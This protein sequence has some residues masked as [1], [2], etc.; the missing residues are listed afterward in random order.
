MMQAPIL[1][2]DQDFI[3]A[4]ELKLSDLAA[5]WRGR[6]DTPEADEVVRQYQAVL[7]CMIELGFRSSLDVDAELPNRLMP[8]EYSDLFKK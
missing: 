1:P 7:R 6:K 5:L 3:G 4:M 2:V 8:Q